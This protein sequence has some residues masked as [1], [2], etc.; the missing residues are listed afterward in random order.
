VARKKSK[1]KVLIAPRAERHLNAIYS[2]N[3]E[4]RELL[5]ADRYIAFLYSKIDSLSTQWLQGRAVGARPNLLY[6]VAKIRAS[7]DGH[8]IVYTIHLEAETLE[9]IGVFHTKQDWQGKM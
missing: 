1:L 7:G 6:I 3:L 2:Y 5:E 8:I 9:I 4:S